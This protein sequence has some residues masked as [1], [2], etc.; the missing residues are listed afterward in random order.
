MG[1]NFGGI[2]AV[3]AHEITH[4]FDDQGKKYDSDGN[5]NDWWNDV[6]DQNFK[7]ET[8]K[9][10][11]LFSSYKLFGKNVNGDLTLGENIAD[12]GGVTI[13]YNSLIKYLKEF[14]NEDIIIDKFN[15]KQRFFFNYA[16]IWKSK[17]REEDILQRLLTDPHSPPEFRV[18]GIL[19]HLDEFYQAFNIKEDSKLFLKNDERTSIF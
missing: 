3:I 19:I 18:N 7:K 6:D 11:D 14:P 16:N 12:L 5:L 8:G 2:G 17:S 4:G 9:L 10:K 15:L 13:A 1:M